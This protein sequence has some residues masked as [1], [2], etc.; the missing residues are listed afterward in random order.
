M[1]TFIINLSDSTTAKFVY[2]TT[3]LEEISITCDIPIDIDCLKVTGT[4][5]FKSVVFDKKFYNA[6]KGKIDILDLSELKS[7]GSYSHMSLGLNNC[8]ERCYYAKVKNIKE[9]ILPDELHNMPMIRTLPELRKIVGSGLLTFDNESRTD[10]IFSS[11]LSF[12]PKL[13]EIVFGS[14]IKTI[15]IRKSSIKRI[16]IPETNG[17]L[18]LEPYGFAYNN[19]LEE[20]HIPQDIRGLPIRLFE[21]CK[22]LRTIIGGN[23]LEIIGFGAFGGCINLHSIP[24]RIELL[25]ENQFLSYEEW[26]Q[27]EPDDHHT[28][29]WNKG[30]CSHCPKGEWSEKDGWDAGCH[31]QKYYCRDNDQRKWKPYKRGVVL[32]NGYIWCFDDFTYYKTD[33]EVSWLFKPKTIH[34][35]VEF[36][37]PNITFETEGDH[38]KINYNPQ[39]KKALELTFPL[40]KLAETIDLYFKDISYEKILEDITREVDELDIDAII[41]SYA[42]SFSHELFKMNSD[43]EGERY[44]LDRSAKYTDSYLTRLLPSFHEHYDDSTAGHATFYSGN[45]NPY[46]K[47]YDFGQCLCTFDKD[48]KEKDDLS[49]FLSRTGNIFRDA[50]NLRDKDAEIRKE[51]REK[52]SREDHVNYLVNCRISEIINKKLEIESRLHI[53]Q[54][55]NDF[56]NKKK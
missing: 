11:N 3:Y 27:F 34:K 26:M 39:E 1:K 21:G 47:K 29:L 54:A 43:T 36:I 2:H 14:N 52:Y 35:Y 4:I 30:D 56:Y 31:L 19:E 42:T 41:D 9:I 12:C 15:S 10:Y 55:E 13:E 44:N 16:N 32:E 24:F 22:K 18:Q 6:I 48:K 40:N 37:S 17:L 28:S 8:S 23:G 20:V 33:I 50:D 7:S 49:L 38:V 5:D 25:K 46:K 45:K 51:A 53:R